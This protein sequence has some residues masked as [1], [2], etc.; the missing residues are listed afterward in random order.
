MARE[1]G[2]FRKIE[3]RAR[4]LSEW[5]RKNAP[6]CYTE[7]KH[8]EEGSQERV[9]WHYGYLAALRDVV[10]LLTDDAASSDNRSS[11]KS[12]WNPLA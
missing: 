7:Q 3:D 10:R 11:G 1:S 4:V 5:L 6:E 9:Y 2:E 8:L 12:D